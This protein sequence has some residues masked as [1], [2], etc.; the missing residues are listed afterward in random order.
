MDVSCNGECML[1]VY[2]SK[3]YLNYYWPV[4]VVVGEGIFVSTCL[5]ASLVVGVMLDV[6]PT[7]SVWV[8]FVV[9]GAVDVKTDV[10]LCEDTCAVVSISFLVN[11]S[12]CFESTGIH[13]FVIS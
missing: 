6:E 4:S 5:L 12:V 9:S 1:M 13:R 7:E 3:M 2:T 10:G 11:D 8:D